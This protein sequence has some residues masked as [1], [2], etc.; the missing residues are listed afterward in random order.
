MPKTAELAGSGIR[1]ARLFRNG[2]NQALRIPKDFEL[3][4]TEAIITKEKDR[5]LIEPVRG[6]RRL[7]DVLAVLEPLTEEFP[8]VDK[9]LPPADE[10][11]L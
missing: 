5:L 10:V 7:L 1:R 9:D 4:G 3:P 2:R 8:D 6:K 11:N